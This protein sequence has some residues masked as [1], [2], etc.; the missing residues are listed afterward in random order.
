YLT[1]KTYPNISAAFIGSFIFA[2]I[3]GFTRAWAAEPTN[4]CAR[5]ER[6]A[7]SQIT[8]IADQ[9]YVPGSRNPLQ[10]LDIYAPAKLGTEPALQAPTALA[11]KLSTGLSTKPK[12]MLAKK[13]P[14]IIYIHGGSFCLGDK[15]S[16]VTTMPHVFTRNGFVFVSIDY[17]LSPAV[18]FPAHVQD[19]ASAIA[20]IHR[21]IGRY[22][23][24]PNRIFLLGHS[25]GAQLAALVSTD[26]RYL[27]WHGLSLKTVSG[28]VLLDGGA[29]DVAASLLTDKRRPVKSPAFGSNPAVW[30][31]ASPIYHVKE[32]RNIPPFLIYYLPWTIQSTEQNTKLISALRRARVPFDVH[33]IENKNH[34]EINEA[35]GNDNDPEGEQIIRFFNGLSH[36]RP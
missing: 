23:G 5:Q 22:G 35:L 28:V 7:G 12:T 9:V 29:L 17:R 6:L 18:H 3:F 26:Q 20:W 16:S 32:G 21:S 36:S 33:V 31:Q 8:L 15:V 10:R 2:F 13:L 19:V 34:R 11:T 25:A 14:V 4:V 30:R 24:D 1:N 27:F